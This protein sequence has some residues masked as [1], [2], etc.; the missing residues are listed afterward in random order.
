MSLL[1]EHYA[2][3]FERSRLIVAVVVLAATVGAVAALPNLQTNDSFVSLF[4][5][6]GEDDSAAAETAVDVG[7]NDNIC[8]VALESDDLFTLEGLAVV[9]DLH[10]TLSNTEGVDRVTS[11]YDIRRPFMLLRRRVYRRMFP[12]EDADAEE[13]QEFRE[14]AADHPM[15]KQ[16]LL[17][18]DNRAT[19]LIVELNPLF[20]RS[21]EFRPVLNQIEERVAE[22]TRDENMEVEITGPTVIQ[23]R[24]ADALVKDQIVF[25]V[26]GPVVAILVSL[27]LFRRLAAVLI[28]TLAPIMG[29]VWTLGWFAVVGEE[30]NPINGVVAPLALTIGLT[31]AVHML[32]HIRNAIA[33][34]STPQDA[35]G[36]AIRNAAGLAIRHV[37]AAC[38]LT[39]LT[40]AVGFAS[41]GIADMYVLR[42]FGI[43]CA[44]A[45]VCAFLAVVTIVPLLGSTPLGRA[46]VRKSQSDERLKTDSTGKW[47]VRIVRFAVRRRVPVLVVGTILTGLLIWDAR[48]LEL[49]GRIRR[50]LPSGSSTEEAFLRVDDV[51]GGS[52]PFMLVVE[53]SPD[54]PPEPAELVDVVT[55]AHE[56]LTGSGVNS[57]P[58][59]ILS[60]F[61]MIPG[62]DRSPERL[63]GELSHVPDERLSLFYD[64]ELGRALIATRFRDAGSQEIQAALDE[65]DRKLALVAKEHDSFRF[66]TPQSLPTFLR[67]GNTILV[68]LINSLFLAVPITTLIIML[69]F[70]SPRLGLLSLL[71]NVFPMAALASTMLV[72]GIPLQATGTTVFVICFGVAVDD[73]IHALS[74]FRRLCRAGVPANEAIERAFAEIGDAIIST[75]IILIAGL[76][77]VMLGQSMSTRYFGGLFIIGLLWAI[78]ADLLLLPALLAY[79][80]P[81]QA[82]TGEEPPAPHPPT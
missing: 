55:A 50:G 52:L 82:K 46:T 6:R 67:S 31:D 75:T 28:V 73:T 14:L 1:I 47:H 74:V 62:T 9:R 12:P 58:L 45:V 43:D 2:R 76:S 35:A 54:D 72:L 42:R 57:P 68:D 32:L 78:L 41:L 19:Q 26:A 49:D 71:P 64:E 30:L 24:A 38:M 27:V 77:V 4:M 21:S 37:G 70:R 66:E 22:R 10:E 40:T 48:R 5:K 56:S 59:S 81:R 79:F 16:Q 7:V 23:V 60:I 65:M 36:D 8:L 39:T 25:N 63:V 29:V 44:V 80:P 69:A 3:L 15:I 51:F 33:S 20:Q 53:W 18:A 11:L 61:E 34:G 17:S 13:I